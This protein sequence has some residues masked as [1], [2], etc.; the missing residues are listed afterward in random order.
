VNLSGS[1][2]GKRRRMGKVCDIDPESPAVKGGELRV[3][4]VIMTIDDRDSTT[5]EALVKAL[6]RGGYPTRYQSNMS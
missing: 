5:H 4:D 6:I 3:G 1:F 2:M